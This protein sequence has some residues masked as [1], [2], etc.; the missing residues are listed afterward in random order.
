MQKFRAGVIDECG[1]LCMTR[2]GVLSDQRCAHVDR[3]CGD[4][5]AQFGEPD[6]DEYPSINDHDTYGGSINI[7]GSRTLHFDSLKDLR[8]AY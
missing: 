5:C 1:Y 6:I 3:R 7:C 8:H 4:W 2:C